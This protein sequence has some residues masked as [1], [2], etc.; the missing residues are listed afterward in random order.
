MRENIKYSPLALAQL[1]MIWDYGF[2]RFGL[3]QA[4]IYIDGLLDALDEI[5]S[6]WAY[7]GLKP[8]PVPLDKIADITSELIYFI[9]YK[10]EIIYL[11]KMAIACVGVPCLLG[12]RM[13][14][15]N[16]L[17]EILSTPLATIN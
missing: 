10:N 15:P 11:K 12:V 4:D 7:K 13:D 3:K 1:D 8:R 6:S 5:N 17:K 9:P 16:R 2:E 14:T